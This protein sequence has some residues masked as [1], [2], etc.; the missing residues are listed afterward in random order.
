M[1]R[2]IDEFGQMVAAKTDRSPFDFNGY[3]NWCGLGGSGET[4]DEIDRYTTPF[5]IHLDLSKFLYR[6]RTGLKSTSI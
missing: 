6:V 2:R 3:G 4:V 1:K 5:S